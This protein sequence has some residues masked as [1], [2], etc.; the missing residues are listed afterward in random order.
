MHCGVQF[1]MDMFQARE[2]NVCYRFY[3]M[4]WKP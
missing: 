3:A 1:M 4:E 2:A